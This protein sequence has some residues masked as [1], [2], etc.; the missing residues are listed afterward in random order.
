MRHDNLTERNALTY[1]KDFTTEDTENHEGCTEV[2]REA[3]RC[4][5][6][7]RGIDRRWNDDADA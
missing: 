6:A 2:L 7:S 5:I 4:D 1:I 3:H